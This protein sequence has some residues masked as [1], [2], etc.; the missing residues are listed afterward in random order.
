MRW[1]E[2]SYDAF[3]DFTAH[4][5]WTIVMPSIALLASPT[6]MLVE[7]PKAFIPVE[8]QGYLITAIQTPDG[9]GREATSKVAG[10]DQQD[11]AWDWKES[12]TSSC[13]KASTS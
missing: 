9:T 4:H 7:R 2:N 6:V 13:S 12:A 1:L 8:D 5:W 10:R 3:L 11:R